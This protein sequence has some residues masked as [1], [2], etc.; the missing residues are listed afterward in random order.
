M[1]TISKKDLHRIGHLRG[2]DQY[3][4]LSDLSLLVLC[5][6]DRYFLSRVA[7]YEDSDHYNNVI[8]TRIT[9]FYN[10]PKGENAFECLG[11]EIKVIEGGK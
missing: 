9:L 2:I 7:N 10:T 8:Y 6:G 11:E 5:C 4:V 3:E 1:K